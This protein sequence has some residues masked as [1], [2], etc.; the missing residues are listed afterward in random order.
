[1][2]NAGRNGEASAFDGRV[3]DVVSNGVEA[4]SKLRAGVEKLLKNR[5]PRAT[6]VIVRAEILLPRC[7]KNEAKKK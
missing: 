3:T 4:K 5:H 7:S 2:H 1:M 6:G